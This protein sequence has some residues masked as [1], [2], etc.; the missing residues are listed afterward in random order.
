MDDTVCIACDTNEHTLRRHTCGR[1]GPP[2]TPP[3]SLSEL[4]TEHLIKFYEQWRGSYRGAIAYDDLQ[5]RSEHGDPDAREYL[6][7][8][9]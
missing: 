5:G 2:P 4:N 1:D 8:R 7:R 9:S 6:D 3:V